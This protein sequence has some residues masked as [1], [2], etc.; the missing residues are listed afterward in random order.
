MQVDG[1]EHLLGAGAQHQDDSSSPHRGHRGE[2]VLEH[3]PA[4]ELGELL[5]A[6]EAGAF[7]CGKDERTDHP[8]V[9]PLSMTW[10][11]RSREARVFPAMNR[12]TWGS[13]AFIPRASGS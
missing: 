4:V 1:V 11:K 6:A 10:A 9:N 13:A 7:P 3:R 5:A 2:R 12:S 8:S